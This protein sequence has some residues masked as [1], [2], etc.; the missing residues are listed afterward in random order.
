MLHATTPATGKNA[1]W[2]GW[3]AGNMA[4]KRSTL[5][6]KQVHTLTLSA[7][8]VDVDVDVGSGASVNEHRKF[9]YICHLCELDKALCAGLVVAAAV[10]VLLLL[11]LVLVIK[12]QQQ[13]H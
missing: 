12:Q 10:V 6:H 3:L 5:T 4:T 11:L 9:V 8:N 2:L 7:V 1:S 13:Q